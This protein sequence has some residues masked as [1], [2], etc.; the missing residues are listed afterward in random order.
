MDKIIVPLFVILIVV[1]IMLSELLGPDEL[2]EEKKKIRE[3]IHKRTW[4]E[5][6]ERFGDPSYPG[7]INY[8]EN[9]EKY[10]K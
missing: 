1:V 8:W 10:P 3:E 4:K 9:D 2:S 6:D 7:S 5:E